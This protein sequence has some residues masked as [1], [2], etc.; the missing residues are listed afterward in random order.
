MPRKKKLKLTGSQKRFLRD[1]FPDDSSLFEPEKTWIYGTDASRIFVPPLAVVRPES[2]EQIKE[3]LAWADREKIPVFSRARGT[4]VVGAC[5]PEYRGIVISSLKM[6][7]VLEIDEE[8]FTAVVE[9]GVVTA[10][11]QA[12]VRSKGLYYPPDPASVKISTLGGNVS[13]N[14]GGLRAV[15]YGVTKDY[16]LGL[17]AVLPG[18]ELISTGR[19]VYKDVVGLDTTSLL[20]GSE[21]TLAFYTKIILKLLSLPDTSASVLIG[22]R[23]LAA[24]MHSANQVFKSGLS[25]V[26]MEF[27]DQNTIFCLQK[28]GA[29][30]FAE[31][32]KSMLLLQ[33]E[34]SEDNINVDLQRLNKMSR[35]WDHR[36]F[37]VAREQEQ[38]SKLWEVRRQINPASF[39]MGPDKKSV[40]VSVPRGKLQKALDN[41]RK[42]GEAF[43]LYVLTFGHLGDGN[44][45]VN[46]MYDSRDK[47]QNTAAEKLIEKV[48]FVVLELGG[49]ISGEHGVGLVKKPYLSRQLGSKERGLMQGIKQVFDPGNI[50]NPNKAF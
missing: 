4:N 31:N 42:A 1:L 9:P 45:H 28:A 23:D 18:G 17:E 16:V 37:Q 33:F 10:D 39:R 7:R 26:A 34:G 38:E 49:S 22:F 6:N 13:T 35:G 5:V 25:P 3:F 8:D 30:P 11:F 15:K 27:L 41:I 12:T 43:G 20:V 14:A 2:V 44:I 19:K 29:S 36:T 50:M 46:V 32:I 40:D 24:L 48:L 21:G 47:S